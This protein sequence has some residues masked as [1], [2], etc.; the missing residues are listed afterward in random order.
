MT[1]VFSRPLWRVVERNALVSRRNWYVYLAGGAEPFIYLFSVGVGVGALV[2]SVAGPSGELVTYR[3]FVAPAML[4]GAA[5]NSAVFDSTINFFVR[6]KYIQT[7]DAMLA[8]PLTTRDLVRGELA[9]SLSRVALY[10]TTFI[11]TMLALG[12]LASPWAV[13]ALP[14]TLLLAFAFG[15][16]GMAAST[17][18]RS[19]LDFDMVFL[20]I[21]PMFLFSATFFP[22]DRYPRGLQLVV[23]V[24]PLYHG[25]DLLRRLTLGGVGWAQL[26]SVAYLLALAVFGLHVAERRVSRLLQP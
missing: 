23:Q 11:V 12:L 6:F 14:A 7:Y 9:W 10:S 8:T 3:E 17:W 21:V 2:D 24:T 25:A 16:I 22:L 26:G 18:L 15:G 20:A 4:A 13:L 1:A 5:M 19:W